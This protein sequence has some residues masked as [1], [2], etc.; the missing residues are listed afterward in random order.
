MKLALLL[1]NRWICSWCYLYMCFN[2]SRN[3]KSFE[4]KIGLQSVGWVGSTVHVDYF[5]KL[6]PTTTTKKHISATYNIKRAQIRVFEYAR[7]T[8]GE[9]L[10][11]TARKWLQKKKLTSHTHR[12]T[13]THTQTHTN[14]DT[15]I[16]FKSLNTT[17]NYCLLCSN[18]SAHFVYSVF[19]CSCC[20]CSP[21]SFI[22]VRSQRIHTLSL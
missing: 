18:S 1:T 9:K 19:F 15:Y 13:D 22:F 11:N 6:K 2:H 14:K 16:E 7:T 4:I 12:Q 17:K 5:R 10:N 21:C 3:R 8:C 20:C